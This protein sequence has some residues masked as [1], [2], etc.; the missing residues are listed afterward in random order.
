MTSDLDAW[1]AAK[2]LIDKHGAG[3]PIHAAM[4][5]DEFL[6]AADGEALELAA[7]DH[8]PHVRR[9]ATPA[10]GQRDGRVG[11]LR[12]LGNLPPASSKKRAETTCT[13]F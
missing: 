9:R 5:A 12:H 3:T 8:V 1:R 11:A 6:E 13:L 4:R 10:L 2:L 7:A